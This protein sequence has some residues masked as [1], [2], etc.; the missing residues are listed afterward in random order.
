MSQA[1]ALKQMMRVIMGGD[2]D[3]KVSFTMVRSSPPPGK[4]RVINLYVDPT[5]GKLVVEYEDTPQP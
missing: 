1:E 4:L 2:G 5:T 3:T